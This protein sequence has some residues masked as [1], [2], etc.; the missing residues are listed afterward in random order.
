MKHF[1]GVW[2]LAVPIVYIYMNYISGTWTC[3]TAVR[4][5]RTVI[6]I[7]SLSW[8]TSPWCLC[9]YGPPSPAAAPSSGPPSSA[10][11]ARAATA[12][13]APLWPGCSLAKRT[14]ERK[15]M[16]GRMLE[17][18]HLRLLRSEVGGLRGCSGVQWLML[19]YLCRLTGVRLKNETHVTP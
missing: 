12:R 5:R 9:T 19:H 14:T 2:I 3:N 17:Q 1:K 18:S 13:P 8:W 16:T 4:C 11:H 7:S 6:C 15:P 10:S